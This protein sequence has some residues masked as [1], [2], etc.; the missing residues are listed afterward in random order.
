MALS[1]LRNN[2]L[3]GP[4]LYF[5]L[6]GALGCSSTPAPMPSSTLIIVVNAS[7]LVFLLIIVLKS[8]GGHPPAMAVKS[9]FFVAVT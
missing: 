5:L 2:V 3:E 1:I 6:L 7:V 8:S 9:V 4:T